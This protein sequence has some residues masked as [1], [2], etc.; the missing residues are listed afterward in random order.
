MSDEI[1]RA[2]EF[3]FR[4]LLTEEA[5][6]TAGRRR[7]AAT[8]YDLEEIAESL[9]LDALDEDHVA[10]A[11][12]MSV[13]YI[14]VA[15]FENSVR[16]FIASTLLEQHGVNWWQGQ[17][18]KAI[19]DQVQKRIEDEAKHRWHTPRGTDPIDFTMLPQ[20]M[21]II[22]QNQVTFEPFI[23][24]LEWAANIFEVIDRSRNVIMHSGTLASRDIK[25]LGT[26]IRDWIAQVG[27]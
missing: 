2:Y 13:V 9:A 8:D 27:I 11:R 4:G 21:N 17:V 23:H 18:S 15:A 14:A 1:S 25:R 3:A 26:Y 24:D 10:R 6:D 20:L 12:A 7:K 19:K 5:L 16:R 22:R